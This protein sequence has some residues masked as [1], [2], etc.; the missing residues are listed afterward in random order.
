V[1]IRILVQPE[2][3]RQLG[4]PR[5]SRKANIKMGLQ[6]LGWGTEWID[7]AQVTIRC[8]TVVNEV[9]KLQLP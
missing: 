3:W 9:M 5:H 7:L 1:G 8:Q 6:L 2:G 4:R